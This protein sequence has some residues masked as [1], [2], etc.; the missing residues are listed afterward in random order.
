MN[1]EVK[2]GGAGIS[3]LTAAINLKLA[4]FNVIVFEKEYKVGSNHFNDWEGLENW[5][6]EENVLDFLKNI[7]IGV[8]FYYKPCCELDIFDCKG[9]KFIAKSDSRSPL[10]YLVKRG[11]DYDSLDEYLKRR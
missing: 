1:K 4:G 2:I 7:N 5:S 6:K 10:L 9:K 3:G 11:S 8:D